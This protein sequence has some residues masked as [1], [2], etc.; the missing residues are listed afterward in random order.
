M[1]NESIIIEGLGKQYRLYRSRKDKY[2]EAFGLGRV[3]RIKYEEF[4]ALRGINLTAKK[5]ERVGLIGRNGAGKSTLLKCVM[6]GIIPTEGNVTVNGQI[7][8]LMQLGTGFHP[9]F[10]GYENINAYLSYQGLSSKEI[11]AKTAEIVDFAE[12]GDFINQPI[13]T[14][15]AGMSAR[16]SFSAATAIDPEILIIDEVLGAGD[17]YFMQKCIDRMKEITERSGATVLFVSH[18]MTSV[19]LLCNR[20]VWIERGEII[21]DDETIVISKAYSRMV[22]ER[23]E[24]RLRLK[25]EQV[26]QNSSLAPANMAEL[27]LSLIF[28]FSTADDAKAYVGSLEFTNAGIRHGMHVGKTQDTSTGYEMFIHID[29]A[30]TFWGEPQK[31]DEVACRSVSGKEGVSQVYVSTKGLYPDE[32]AVFTIQYRSDGPVTLN[33]RLENE[34]LPVTT[35]ESTNGEWASVSVTLPQDMVIYLLKSRGYLAEGES[36]AEAADLEND[37]TRADEVLRIT[38]VRFLDGAGQNSVM[39][40]TFD[41]FCIEVE[42]DVMQDAEAEFAFSLYRSGI[43]AQQYVSGMDT[44]KVY[45]I[46]AGEKR[47]VR[48]EVPALA[49]GRG[50]YYVTI[51]AFPP[52]DYRSTDTE[53]ASYHLMDRRFEIEVEQPEDT[54]F[55]LG[56]C[57]NTCEWREGRVESFE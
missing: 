23:T 32:P 51:G 39:F 17:A 30:M 20:A 29:N 24:R 31:L 12:L 10:N 4:W 52:F 44:G 40:T 43:T 34:V 19:E 1:S 54:V 49:L 37:S 56:I 21:Q 26:Q 48:L 9:D 42:Y 18:D 14:Y 47:K 46:A 45:S 6:G 33:I 22:R 57:R 7:Q 38:R 53:S 8:A 25:N 28:E 15:S 5:G 16:L 35:L 55:D 27:F 50:R 36:P 11:K 2:L 3:S 41:P 13:K